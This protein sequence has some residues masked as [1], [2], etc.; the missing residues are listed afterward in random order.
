MLL[1]SEY[2]QLYVIGQSFVQS[3]YWSSV[4]IIINILNMGSVVTLRNCEIIYGGKYG[5]YLQ[6]IFLLEGAPTNIL[7][8]D[9]SFNFLIGNKWGAWFGLCVL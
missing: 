5:D 9:L 3:I 8:I 7:N 1:N 2:L 4:L 6:N